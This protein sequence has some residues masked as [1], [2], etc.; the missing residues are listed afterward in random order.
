MSSEDTYTVKEMLEEIRRDFTVR[1]DK[2]DAAQAHTNGD[3]R[4]SKL[5]IAFMKGSIAVIVVIVIPMGVYIWNQSQK[6]KSKLEALSTFVQTY[7]TTLHKN[8]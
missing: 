4:K 8:N 1:F 5:D 2:M 3:V 7:E 6:Q